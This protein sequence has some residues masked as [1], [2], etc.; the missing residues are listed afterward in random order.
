MRKKFKKVL[1]LPTRILLQLREELGKEIEERK[2][3]PESD[4][5]IADRFSGDESLVA[6]LYFKKP[7]PKDKSSF[8]VAAKIFCSEIKCQR[9]PHG[10]FYFKYKYYLSG[11]L[12][13][14]YTG[15]PFFD[16]D[17]MAERQHEAEKNTP[18]VKIPIDE[19]S[20]V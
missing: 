5:D 20:N 19:L 12:K 11:N 8:L 10:P 6:K 14:K 18:P 7:Y 16:L 3:R 9:C 1:S 15:R 13:V 17:I 2:N 4:K